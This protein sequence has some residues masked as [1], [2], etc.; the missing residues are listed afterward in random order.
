MDPHLR[1]KLPVVSES[2]VYSN[3]CL[4]RERKI[5]S[6]GKPERVAASVVE[7]EMKEGS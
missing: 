2:L 5:G 1:V 6:F 7:S 4:G 3:S